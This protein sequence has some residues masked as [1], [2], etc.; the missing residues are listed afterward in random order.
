[1][2]TTV[3]I[4]S[5]NKPRYLE[6][7]LE[8][9]RH[10][11]V[12]DQKPDFDIIIADDGSSDETKALIDTVKKDFPV[13]IT[14]IWHKDDGFRKC[15]IL[16]KAIATATDSDY[17]IFTD[18]DCIPLPDFV[19]SH[20]KLASP[21]S[22]LS[23]GAMRMPQQLTD[24]IFANGYKKI[25]F[26]FNWLHQHGLPD[27]L[28]YKR[29]YWTQFTRTL[30]D[31]LVPVKKTFNGN[32]TSVFRKDLLKVGGFDERM[33]YYGEDV[34]LGLRLENSGVTG[35]R[36]RHR[37]RALHLEHGRAYVT[38][39]MIVKNKI[40]ISETLASKRSYSE[41]HVEF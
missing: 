36:V 9:Y 33:Q 13:N 27:K 6:L 26:S 25:N 8:G 35:K 39:E 11:S 32:N 10:Q 14:H 40:I 34:E 20:L 28:K 19:E 17:L 24:Y 37:A 29:F 38:E 30:L 31:Y 15:R 7:A 2:R 3:I 18:D 16:N 23:S 5:Y 41:N 4:A 1:M 12:R 21:K 22:F